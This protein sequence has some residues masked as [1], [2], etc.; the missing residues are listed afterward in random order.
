MRTLAQQRYVS[1]TDVAKLH[2][3]R[4]EYDLAFEAIEQARAERR[5]WLAYLRVEPLLDPVRGDPRYARLL[6]RMQLA[7]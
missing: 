7:A 5:G 2:L 1:P 3:A 6:Q 4:G